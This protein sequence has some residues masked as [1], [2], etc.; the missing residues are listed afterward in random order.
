MV[1]FAGQ[2]D[3]EGADKELLRCVTTGFGRSRSYRGLRLCRRWLHDNR[4]VLPCS[5]RQ[6]QRLRSLAV[7]SEPVDEPPVS[8]LAREVQ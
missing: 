8:S 3:H 4:W 5:V 7:K 6:S 2:Q 1:E